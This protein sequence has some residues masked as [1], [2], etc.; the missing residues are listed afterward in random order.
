M[1]YLRDKQHYIDLYDRITVDSCRRNRQHLIDIFK[2]KDIKKNTEEFRIANMMYD[3]HLYFETGDEYRKKE[4]TVES[5]MQRDRA[6]DLKL[7]NADP[8]IGVSCLSCG[9]MMECTDKDLHEKDEVERIL[10]WYTCSHGCVKKRLFYDN[11]EE[12]RPSIQQCVKC[13]ATMDIT[14]SRNEDIVI[15][16][17]TC[18]HCNHV[19]KETL[20]LSDPEP[21]IDVEYEKDRL[22]FCL[23]EEKG[24]EYI[25]GLQRM[26]SFSKI[27]EDIKERED[28]KE[29]YDAIKKIRK[30][31]FG[32]VQKLLEDTLIKGFYTNLQF[33]TPEMMKGVTVEFVVVDSKSGREKYDS[34]M[35]LKKLMD[36][37]LKGTNWKLMSDGVSYNLGFLSGRIKGKDI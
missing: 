11:S 15:T 17:Y 21:V 19:E 6:R 26:E 27:V 34:R 5:W 30:L 22:E 12:W 13:R 37:T 10:F 9:K 7:Q 33:K 32:E 23:S 3:L 4:S 35:M 20:N 31:V 28:N 14:N 16:T 2:E 8:L 36:K 18:P 29:K 25:Q 1:M 24:I